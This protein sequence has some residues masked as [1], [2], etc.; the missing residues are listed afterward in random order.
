[1]RYNNVSF[2]FEDRKVDENGDCQRIQA[3]EPR[4]IF[5]GDLAAK[6][7]LTQAKEKSKEDLDPAWMFDNAVVIKDERK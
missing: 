6:K 7:M 2:L 4:V 5:R 3:A 1:M